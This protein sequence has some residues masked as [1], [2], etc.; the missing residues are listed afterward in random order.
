MKKEKLNLA[1]ETLNADLEA[2]HERKTW[3]LANVK[4]IP[5]FVVEDNGGDDVTVSLAGIELMTIDD[6]DEPGDTKEPGYEEKVYNYLVNRA[7][8]VF[9][10]IVGALQDL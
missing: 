3:N 7:R 9:G 10:P 4:A 5:T 1:V 2:S 8:G 6:I